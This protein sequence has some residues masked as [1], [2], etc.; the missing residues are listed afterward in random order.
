M[1][2]IAVLDLRQYS[3]ICFLPA[4]IKKYEDI[5]SVGYLLVWT[6]D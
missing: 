5:A 3:S 4:S 1:D 2:K 6:A